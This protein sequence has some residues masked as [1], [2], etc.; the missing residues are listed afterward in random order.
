[1]VFILSNILKSIQKNIKI[2][3]VIV[4][5]LFIAYLF[6]FLGCCYIED[7]MRDM[8][9]FHMKNASS[10]IRYKS[11]FSNNSFNEISLTDFENFFGQYEFT[12]QYTIIWENYYYNQLSGEGFRYLSIMDN[13]EDFNNVTLLDGRFFTED[14]FQNDR[15]V[16]VVEKTKRDEE[17]LV[18][19]DQIRIETVDYE[20][21]GIIK[22]NADAG[23]TWIS[24]NSLLASHSAFQSEFQGY[25]INA[26][27]TDI[28]RRF[29]IDW[30]QLNMNGTL[31]TADEYYL[32]NRDVLLS[33][34]I[35]LFIISGLILAYTLLNLINIFVGKLD[36]QKKSL[37][38]R[39]ALGA[40]YRQ[41]FLQ[42][43]LECL[44][45][46]LSAIV[47]VFIS[48][49]VT[50]HLVVSIINHY[51]GLF[52]FT[53]MIFVS[54]LSSFIISIILFRKFRKMSIVEIVSRA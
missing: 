42:F 25:V 28:T 44:T 13:Y 32:E 5:T 18:L 54:L 33:R 26:R 11:N 16:C 45:L 46:V 14:D 39:I 47:F 49:P 36:D 3:I 37:C 7:G 51:F 20:I 2:N 4:V 15:R 8:N 6:F 50:K 52:S 41:I 27:L 53:A 1:M 22:R 9:S 30:H 34:S 23:A 10:S 19:G 12:E 17:G 40:S 24:L 43:F 31:S 48:E 35:P 38:I 21:I 29:D